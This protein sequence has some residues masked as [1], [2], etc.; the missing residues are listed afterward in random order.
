MKYSRVAGWGAVATTSLGLLLSFASSAAAQPAPAASP[1][2]TP[3]EPPTHPAAD[4]SLPPASPA[5]AETPPATTEFAPA[6]KPAPLTLGEPAEQTEPPAPRGPFSQGSV[7]L[8]L[9]LGTGYSRD[10]TYFII[11]GGLGYYLVNGLEVGLD[12]EAWLFAS[13]VMHRLSPEARYVFHMVPLIKPYAGVFYRRTFVMEDNPDYN[14][15]GAR[16]GAYYVPRSGRMYIG[17][18]AVYEKT[19][20]CT[21]SK[22]LDC[23]SWYPEISVGISL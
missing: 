3:K 22:Y 23:D 1:A 12:Y 5:D 17:G 11:G 18:G 16:L 7:R 14:Q 10:D 8:T 4:E 9:L 19:L 15:V 13:P 20:D 21:D 6:E 2:P